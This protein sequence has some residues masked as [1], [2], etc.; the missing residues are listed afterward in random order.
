MSYKMR[1]CPTR[2]E[3][4]TLIDYCAQA[5]YIY[6]LGLE[7]RR[8]FRPWHK[9][10]KAPIT[11]V[12]QCREL[13]GLR[14]AS[15]WVASGPAIIQQSALKDL[16]RAYRNWWMNPAHFCKPTWRKKHKHEGF[17]LRVITFGQYNKKWG[18]IRVPKLGKVKFRLTYQLGTLKDCTSARIT[19]K[20]GQWFVSFTHTQTP[21]DRHSTGKTIGIDMGVTHTITT[22]T[23]EHFSMPPPTR[24]DEIKKLQRK[25]SRQKRSSSRR[26]TTLKRLRVL[27][28]KQQNRRRDWVEKTTTLLVKTYDHIG[29]EK[30][31]TQHMMKRPK[32]QP[33]PRN[34]GHYLPNQASAKAG[35]NR[36]ISHN[37]WGHIIKRLTDKTNATPGT[38]LVLVDPK[39]TSV[40]CHTCRNKGIRESQAIFFCPTCDTR[41]NADINAAHNILARSIQAVSEAG[42]AFVTHITPASQAG[43]VNPVK[44]SHVSGVKR[45]P[46]P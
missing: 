8:M 24:G 19:C 46:L 37:S 28:S 27:S 31:S 44:P 33:D 1:L 36:A 21:I 42:H 2:V 20:A 7:Q 41:M 32:P 25:L 3:E 35:L 18:W 34:P 6:N 5:R 4:N 45:N 40:T 11:W 30:L 14:A 43:R 17:H 38:S 22:S 10:R 9:G 29:A 26:Q 23:G 15:P 16:D 13:T 39:Y 12:T